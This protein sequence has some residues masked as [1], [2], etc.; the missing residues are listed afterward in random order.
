MKLHSKDIEELTFMEEGG[1]VSRKF[2]SKSEKKANNLKKIKRR[3]LSQ[4]NKEYE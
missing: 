3:N 4:Y 2:K 1:Y